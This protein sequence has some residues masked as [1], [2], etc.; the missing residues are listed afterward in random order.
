MSIS[1]EYKFGAQKIFFHKGGNASSDDFPR[2]TT[3][4]SKLYQ[5]Y[6][7][8]EYT[9]PSEW[10]D[11][12]AELN[13]WM[14]KN[15]SALLTKFNDQELIGPGG[16][17]IRD[18][19][20]AVAE[21]DQ[22]FDSSN[23]SLK[24]REIA[25]V[26]LDYQ[27]TDD[28]AKT[29]ATDEERDA[30]H[31]REAGETFREDQTTAH[32][33]WSSDENAASSISL[34]QQFLIRNVDGFALRNSDNIAKQQYKN[35]VNILGDPQDT[36]TKFLSKPG[37][38][39]LLNIT[40][41]QRAAIVPKIRLYKV[42]RPQP[43]RP[44]LVKEKE[45]I[46]KN[47][48]EVNKVAPGGITKGEFGR[49]TGVG[50]TKLGLDFEGTNLAAAKKELRVQLELHFQNFKSLATD[51]HLAQL[52]KGNPMTTSD[53][54]PT[55]LDLVWRQHRKKK[56]KS[57]Q[58][59]Y[60]P[61]HF[62]IKLVV[63]WSAP[64]SSALFTNE[65]RS[66]IKNMTTAIY[67]SQIDHTFS[68]NQDGSIDLSIEFRGRIDETLSGP[69]ADILFDQT[70]KRKTASHK[71][72]IAKIR[73][74]LSD[75]SLT[76]DKR[77]ELDKK[78]KDAEK[79]KNG[80]ILSSKKEK[81]I[82]IVNR[83]MR[84][85]SLYF[86]DVRFGAMVH[87]ARTSNLS[88]HKAPEGA[89]DGTQATN[90]HRLM[91]SIE[92]ATADDYDAR[93]G[94]LTG[95]RVKEQ[96]KN[97]NTLWYKQDG[98]TK[99]CNSYRLHY[100][101]FGD[102]MDILAD[103]IQQ[104]HP[105]EFNDISYI[106][107]SFLFKDAVAGKQLIPLSSIPISLNYFCNWMVEHVISKQKPMYMFMNFLRDFIEGAL[108]KS[109]ASII[110]RQNVENKNYS[111]QFGYK[112]VALPP[113]TLKKVYDSPSSGA[114]AMAKEAMAMSTA[115]WHPDTPVDQAGL[116]RLLWGRPGTKRSVTARKAETPVINK[117][118][119]HCVIIYPYTGDLSHL[120]GNYAEDVENGIYH[121]G[122]GL[123]KGIVN[124]IQFNKSEIPGH[125]E[126]EFMTSTE[127]SFGQVKRVYNATVRTMG[128]SLFYPGSTIFLNPSIPGLGSP[129]SGAG[130]PLSILAQMGLGG[131]YTV[132]KV[133]YELTPHDF[134]TVLECIWAA[135]GRG[136]QRAKPETRSLSGGVR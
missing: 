86:T 131:Y 27:H 127:E 118:P 38:A 45:F 3:A 61:K 1:S 25:R 78:L 15:I 115:R 56:D 20:A 34:E 2:T 32:A 44:D 73:K 132:Q 70:L 114:P 54:D 72:K 74:Q 40:P 65:L 107:T 49:G 106:L 79:K 8:A 135:S 101:Y 99:S 69:R 76:D 75:S 30:A 128:N 6:L 121:L 55:Y 60:N 39:P 16:I 9:A 48:T 124:E 111:V 94:A 112:V 100:F 26:A 80:V 133:H 123:N 85:D 134:E 109:F 67:L 51:K 96:R 90:A 22:V 129:S 126:K 50:I 92:A 89:A 18:W 28:P 62:E 5:D 13:G 53:D 93:L 91:Q 87:V 12:N 77:K 113:N 97:G 10:T 43:A 130:K 14:V 105:G 36:I 68:F 95:A 136:D 35:L 122:L 119:Q 98:Y 110:E 82:N 4:V 19:A 71:E 83:L 63:G 88:V 120:E 42:Y 41:H 104:N 31:R 21:D 7:G 52:K 117:T 84:H 37:M 81:Y 64:R 108:I 47:F 102:L 116:R 24:A 17:G 103:I 11:P 59:F 23:M 33:D 58:E 57:G 66:A 29:V 46:F 125:R